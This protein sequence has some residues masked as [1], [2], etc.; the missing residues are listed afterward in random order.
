MV[1]SSYVYEKHWISMG[2]TSQSVLVIMASLEDQFQLLP[3]ELPQN[4]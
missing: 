4:I 2:V 1:F 3:A